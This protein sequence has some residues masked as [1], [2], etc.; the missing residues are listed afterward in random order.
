MVELGNCTQLP[1]YL[2]SSPGTE[3]LYHKMGFRRLPGE[4]GKVVHK[5]ELLG[6]ER[7]VEIPLMARQPDPTEDDKEK[8]KEREKRRAENGSSG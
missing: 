1:V 8:Q 3:G 7:D 5:A 2:E 4:M 6:A